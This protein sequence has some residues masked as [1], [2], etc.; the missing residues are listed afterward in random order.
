MNVRRSRL[1]SRSIFG[2]T[3]LP[4]ASLGFAGL[5]PFLALGLAVI[6]APAEGGV[7]AETLLLGYAA[8]IL[9]F[10]GGCRWGFA[11]AGLGDGPTYRQF[12][13]SV[14][15]ALYAWVASQLEFGLAALAL[16]VGFVALFLADRALTRAHGAP[17]WWPVLRLPLTAGAVL[18]LVVPASL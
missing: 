17:A 10:M 15:P 11:A 12:A 8:I 7:W 13:I 16:A 14:G 3:P 9:S 6:A 4:A 5:L 18:A 2:A 1:T